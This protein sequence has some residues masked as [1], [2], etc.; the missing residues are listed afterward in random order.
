MFDFGLQEGSIE[1][2]LNAPNQV[3]VTKDMAT[4]YFGDSK[5][6]VGKNLKL[7]DQVMTVT[8]L[9]NN[10]PV[11]TDFPI[12]IV[13]SYATLEKGIDMNDWGSI[14]DANYCFIQLDEKTGL[15]S[16]D[17]LLQGFTDKHI[18][19]VNPGYDLALQPLK[20][21]HYDERYGNFN[22]RTFG[23]DLIFALSLIG[24]SLSSLLA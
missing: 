23:K 12:K 8:G 1:K 7:F 19:P 14:S 22:G 17:N 10:P 24:C 2:A 18:R 4:K 11:N 6:A 16:F 13:V 9:L 15:K 5:N 3:L 21:M 20:E